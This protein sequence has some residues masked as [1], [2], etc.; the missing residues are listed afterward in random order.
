MLPSRSCPLFVCCLVAASLAAG[1]SRPIPAEELSP[2]GRKL[3][4]LGDAYLRATTL[5]NNRQP[6]KNRDEL[7]AA[8]KLM[9]A[10]H[11][12]HD[13]Y[14]VFPSGGLGWYLDRVMLPSGL[15]ADYQTQ[16]WGW[17]Y[18]ILPYIEQTN[19]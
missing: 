14:G 4:K 9:L 5:N 3:E 7:V 10:F 19:L 16:N 6:P 13:T 1:C 8:L 12:H 11:N 17:G 18:Q 15:P 2:T